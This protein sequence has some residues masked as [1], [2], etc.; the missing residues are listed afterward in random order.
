MDNYISYYILY[1]LLFSALLQCATSVIVLCTVVI[2]VMDYT[3]ILLYC[4][5]QMN[6]ASL[7]QSLTTVVIQVK[8]G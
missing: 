1:M 6:N 3:L 5:I 8:D 4:S 7:G 2:Q